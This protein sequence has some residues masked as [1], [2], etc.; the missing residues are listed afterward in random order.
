MTWTYEAER[1][2]TAL[3]LVAGGAGVALLPLMALKNTSDDR[4]T[5]RSLGDPMIARPIGL[6]SRI[7]QIDTP[8][9]TALKEAIRASSPSRAHRTGE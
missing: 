9:V 4:L 1:S 6:V 8:G 5:W 2:T 3:S 7:G